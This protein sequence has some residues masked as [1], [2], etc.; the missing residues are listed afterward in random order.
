VGMRYFLTGKFPRGLAAN[1]SSMTTAAVG[2]TG[3]LG[4]DLPNLVVGMET[5]NES[6]PAHA[7]GLAISASTDILALVR[8][9]TD[10]FSERPA[11]MDAIRAYTKTWDCAGVSLDGGGLVSAYRE[12]FPAAERLA[13]GELA[14]HF[15]FLAQGGLPAS[16]IKALQHF[17]VTTY[18]DMATERGQAFLAAQALTQG[19][20]QTVS[21]RL[22]SGIDHHDD[23]WSSDHAPALL[24]GFDALSSLLDF[25]KTEYPD[26]WARTIVVASS[27][28]ARTPEINSR[29]GRDHHLSSACIL[30]GAGIKSGTVFG[31]TDDTYT[32]TTVDPATGDPGDTLIRPPDLHATIFEAAGLPWEHLSNQSP[33]VME[34]I[35]S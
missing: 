11:T 5:Y 33:V 19:I 35:L 24:S 26:V 17:G 22:A 31:K 8:P 25:L 18:N 10:T 13:S 23:N 28:F 14:E 6:Q 3:D 1:G 16:T 12:G 30:A 9:L 21:I 29:D 34:G 4:F 2:A 20:A 15:D 7:T 32:R 27:E